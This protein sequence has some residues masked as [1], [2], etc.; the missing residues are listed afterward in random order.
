MLGDEKDRREGERIRRFFEP[1]PESGFEE[2]LQAL[3]KQT[4][5]FNGV[6]RFTLPQMASLARQASRVFTFDSVMVPLASAL[7]KPVVV[8]MGN[9]IPSFGRFPYKTRFTVLEVTGLPCRPC[10]SKG[11]GRCPKGHFRCMMEIALDF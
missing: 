2:G 9:T 4:R 6:G 10:T 1:V 7:R 3:N 5:I 8:I 11:Y